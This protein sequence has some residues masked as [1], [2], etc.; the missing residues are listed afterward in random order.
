MEIEYFE[1][2]RNQLDSIMHVN[3]LGAVALCGELLIITFDY[4][5]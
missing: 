5:R 2:H 3:Y 1:L 4:T